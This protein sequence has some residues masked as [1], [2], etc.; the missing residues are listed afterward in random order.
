[1]ELVQMTKMVSLSRAARVNMLRRSQ[2]F[3]DPRMLNLRSHGGS[4]SGYNSTQKC[5]KCG[6][7]HGPC[8]LFCDDTTCG[9][10]QKLDTK[11]CNYFRIFGMN[12][13]FAIDEPLLEAE[14]K[15]LQKRLHPDKFTTRS[16]EERDRS[17]YNCSVVNQA[18]QV[19]RSP[20]DRAA[21][22][23]Q[24]HD[25][26]IANERTT[27]EDPMMMA[28]VF[29]LN[30]RVEEIGASEEDAVNSM[31]TEVDASMCEQCSHLQRC[32]DRHGP[33]PGTIAARATAS[34]KGKVDLEGARKAAIRLKYLSKVKDELTKK[35]GAC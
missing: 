13:H 35:K 3:L 9:V 18:Y 30:E 28:E 12:E 15:N 6:K 31:I 1:M 21:Y 14:F 7:E 19:L 33:G 10:I 23:L 32:L 26:D 24:F 17:L 5:W 25:V 22:L 8:S 27:F 29:E 34:G 20:M 11:K 16:I 2:L 4:S